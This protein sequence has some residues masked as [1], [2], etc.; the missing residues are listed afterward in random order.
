[1]AIV[2]QESSQLRPNDEMQ[3]MLNS[4]GSRKYSQ[5]DSKS[6]PGL[7]HRKNEKRHNDDKFPMDF[8]GR[9]YQ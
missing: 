8:I 4:R 3:V 9:F 7:L 5:D 1:M 6:Q 2:D